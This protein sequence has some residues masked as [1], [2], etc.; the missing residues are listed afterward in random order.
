MSSEVPEPGKIGLREKKKRKTRLTL[1][2][3]GLRLIREQ[4]Y[5]ATTIEQIAEASEISPSTFFRYFPT[6]EA[7]ILEDD[8][9]PLLIAA[10]LRQP[11][12]L[13][14][15]QAFRAAV[16]EGFAD[17]TGD[18]K[19]SL[20]ERFKLLESVPE[21]RAASLLQTNATMFMI[22]ELVAKRLG[23]V[24]N[25]FEVLLFAG[26]VMGAMMAVHHYCVDHP[27]ADFVSVID[28]ALAF[29]EAGHPLGPL[30]MTNL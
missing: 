1:Q 24:R 7:L 2:Q 25:D 29:Y 27:E 30:G 5:A 20:Y 10:F 15:I 18:E 21:L 22:A 8:N 17:M 9:D 12:E 19:E 26:S 3:Q 13:S 28:R 14:P 23:R 4:G 16:R 6:K 11:A